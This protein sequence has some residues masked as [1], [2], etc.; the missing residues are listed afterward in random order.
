LQQ[1]LKPLHMRYAQ[2]I[3]RMRNWIGH[4]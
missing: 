2:R 4:F 1:T 3:N